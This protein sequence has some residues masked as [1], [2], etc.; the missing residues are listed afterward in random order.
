MSDA[1]ADVL[2]SVTIMRPEERALLEAFRAAGLTAHSVTPRHAAT[3]LNDRALAPRLVVLR[4]ISHRE[5]AGMSGRF[6]QA[7]IPTLNNPHAVRL[8]LSKELQALA[9]ARAGVSHPRTL[10]AFS[11]EQVGEQVAALGGDAVVKPVSGSWGR[12]IVRVTGESEFA[13]WRGGWEALDP[14]ERSF[15]VVVQQYVDKP[16]YNER[17]IVIG[18]RA[19]VAYRQVSDNL[20]T[21]THLGGTVQPVAL[22]P[23]AVELAERVV[24]LFGP[25]F[26]GIDL[27]ESSTTGELFVLEVNTNPEFARSA[28]IHGVDI[29]GLLARY[30]RSV[31]DG[32][33]VDGGPAEREEK[34]A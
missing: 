15:P 16:G 21:N 20:R 17:V 12:G 8:C 14:G 7:G 4:N 30:V 9:F 5:L 34:A 13:A 11:T 24:A 1:P 32:Q 18:D 19:V 27:A 3:F 23:R 10:I 2:V 26:Y 28:G 6:E 33:D 22:S 29:P 31:L 25:G